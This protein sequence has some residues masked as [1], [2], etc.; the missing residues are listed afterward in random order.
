MNGAPT[1]ALHRIPADGEIDDAL[2]GA[3]HSRLR[4]FV[5]STTPDGTLSALRAAADLARHLNSHISL[6]APELVPMRL[7]LDKP[8][9]SVEFLKRRYLD[10]VSAAEIQDE[11]I[12][13]QIWL[14]RDR[15][16]SLEK[17]L[18]QR[19][20]VVIGG[21][22]RW[23]N[24]REQRL[25]VFLRALGHHVVFVDSAAKQRV[26]LD[27]ETDAQSNLVSVSAKELADSKINSRVEMPHDNQMR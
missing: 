26:T 16:S 12:A 15:E 27:A 2:G 8:A 25:A 3:W 13:I 9:V 7:P 17:V 19:S 22:A 1:P 21:S 4:V 11:Q 6:V 24:R 20:L 23:W 10:L 5:V 14:C 18:P